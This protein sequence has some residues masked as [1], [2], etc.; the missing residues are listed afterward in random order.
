MSP[1]ERTPPGEGGA[2]VNHRRNIGPGND[3]VDRRQLWSSVFGPMLTRSQLAQLPKPETLLG[4]YL[5]ARAVNLMHGKSGSY[6]S[7]L[8][9]DWCLCVATGTAWVVGDGP[10]PQPAIYWAAEG[11]IGL[12]ARMEAWERHRGVQV[13]EDVFLVPSQ[14]PTLD[15][16]ENVA[17]LHAMLS[18]IRPGL[19][20]VDTLMRVKGVLAENKADDFGRLF[21][22]QLG[23]IAE[24]TETGILVITHQGQEGGRSRGTTA[25]RD[26]CDQEYEIVRKGHTVTVHHRKSRESAEEPSLQ[27][28]EK[29][30][31][32]SLVLVAGTPVKTPVDEVARALRKLGAGDWF[33]TTEV[34][35]EVGMDRQRLNEIPEQ[36]LIDRKIEKQS[37]GRGK[38]HCWRIVPTTLELDR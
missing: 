11:K 33:T 32:D 18:D 5:Q 36:E 34:G 10:T 16:D 7:F 21:G 23:Q 38:P 2:P 27:L 3:T 28:R 12:D 19:I 1:H 15:S 20:V 13:P 35:A 8:A 29:P 14:S 22:E 24:Q 25:A 17:A 6:K 31:G 30:I 9:L 4:P 26:N 37:Q